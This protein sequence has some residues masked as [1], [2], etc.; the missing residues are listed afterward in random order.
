MLT[1][2][3]VNGRPVQVDAAFRVYGTPLQSSQDWLRLMNARRYR[4]VLDAQNIDEA[5]ARVASAG[6]ATD[7]QYASKLRG[8]QARTPEQQAF[9]EARRGEL[10]GSGANPVLTEL[11]AR[12]A[13]L[14]SAWGASA[15][16]G[17]YYGIKAPGGGVQP[18]P[19]RE[20]RQVAMPNMMQPDYSGILAA[21]QPESAQPAGFWDQFMGSPA[22]QAGLG[23][24]AA[25]GFGGNWLRAVGTGMLAGSENYRK[26]QELTEQQKERSQ[27][28]RLDA[29]TLAY[30]L[31]QDARKQ[32]Y[33][34]TLA[35]QYPEYAAAI[36]AGYGDKVIENLLGTEAPKVQEFYEGGQTVQKQWTPQGWQ[37]VGRGERWSPNQL[38]IPYVA[39]Y[40]DQGRPIMSVDG[41]PQPM[42]LDKTTTTQVQKDLISGQAQLAEWEQIEKEFDPQWQALGSQLENYWN[43]GMDK[44]QRLSPAERAELQKRTSAYATLAG[45]FNERVKAQAGTAM[46]PQEL[47]RL[48]L[49]LPNVSLTPGEGDSPAQ[50]RGKLAA[51]KARVRRAILRNQYLLQN[52]LNLKTDRGKIGLDSDEFKDKVAMPR[53]E[54]RA[55][56]IRQTYPDMPEDEARRQALDEVAAELGI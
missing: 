52:G 44:L 29:A 55:I 50:L 15:P 31:Q 6:Y 26:M 13:A 10:Q 41:A 8:I 12:Q 22:T 35:Q 48:E 11:G 17:N 21:M 33:M 19:E 30:K 16:G 7:P 14:E 37:E 43:I 42:G 56:A 46:T 54:Q 2:E 34:Q 32:A 47:K 53:A 27:K 51:V 5:I 3:Y 9:L 36:Q 1:T 49:E 24:L 38:K 25:P 39:G 23:I 40:D 18:A 20:R 28:Q 4:G 45:T